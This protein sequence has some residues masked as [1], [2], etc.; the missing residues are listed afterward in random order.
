[1][2]MRSM[3]A[4]GSGETSS[5]TFHYTCEMKSLNSRFLEVNVRLPRFLAMLETE[6]VQFIKSRLDRGKVD[7]FFDIKSQDVSETLPN[8]NPDA[9]KHYM[10]CAK[11]IADIAGHDTT[12]LSDLISV[13]TLMRSE[14]VLELARQSVSSQEV[15]DQH[16]SHLM[17]AISSAVDVLIKDR[18]REGESLHQSLTQHLDLLSGQADEVIEKAP[19]IREKLEQNFFKK[20]ETVRK[21]LEDKGLLGETDLSQERLTSEMVIAIDKIDIAEEV[22]R[23]GAH[24]K[25]FR[26]QMDAGDKVGRRLD[27]LCQEMHREINTLS[28]KLVAAEV[29]QLSVAMKQNVERIKQQVQNVE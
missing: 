18:V 21:N 14:G 12:V 22:D 25:E 23:L 16:R 3:T 7:M 17:K 11:K 6:I 8:V 24:I 28:N 15:L 27:F 26:K 1:M 5:D 4:F 19:V 2:P 9:V 29:S 20:M 10:S 13:S